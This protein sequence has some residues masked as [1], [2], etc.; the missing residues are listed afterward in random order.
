MFE[1]V[2]LPP[3]QQPWTIRIALNGTE[4]V[5]VVG[6]RYKTGETLPTIPDKLKELFKGKEVKE[7]PLKMPTSRPAAAA[8]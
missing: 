2:Q 1:N 8:A 6:Y 7:L 5:Y 3:R 4:P